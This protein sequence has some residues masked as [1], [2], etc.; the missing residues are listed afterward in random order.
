MPSRWTN[1]SMLISSWRAASSWWWPI[2]SGDGGRTSS[3]VMSVSIGRLLLRGPDLLEPAEEE[4][5]DDGR[6]IDVA[7]LEQAKDVPQRHG[8]VGRQKLRRLVVG[9]PIGVNVDADDGAV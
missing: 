8:P 9:N 7:L 5:V 2:S 6:L 1:L 3:T 4:D